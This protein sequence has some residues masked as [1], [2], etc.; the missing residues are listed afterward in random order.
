VSDAA[1]PVYARA[2]DVVWRLGPDRVVVRR[3]GASGDATAADLLG[4]VALIWIALDEPAGSAALSDRLVAAG[5]E[6]VGRKPVLDLVSNG[7]L[8][9]DV[10]DD[11]VSRSAWGRRER[12]TR[13]GRNGGSRA[14]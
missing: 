14:P 7:W 3:I 5:V 13:S 1:E 11:P 2:P 4:D 6:P 10:A 12:L 8:T 9:T